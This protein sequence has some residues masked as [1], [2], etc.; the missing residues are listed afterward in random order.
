M[1]IRAVADLH[2][3]LPDI[4]PCDLLLV[5]GDS[6][7]MY[8][9]EPEYQRE[10]CGDV[11]RPWLDSIDAEVVGIGGNHDFIFQADPLVPRDLPWH[12][13]DDRMVEID[14]LKIWGHP[15]VPHLRD[16]AFF[17]DD[18]MMEYIVDEIPDDVD[19][20]LSH[21]PGLRMGSADRVVYGEHVGCPSLTERVEQIKP[22]AFVCGHIHEGNGFYR[23]TV[24]DGF[25]PVYNVAH[26]DK[27]YRPVNPVVE[28]RI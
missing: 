1:I 4:K 24:D 12:Y 5:G 13:A 8:S 23:L 18:P 22:K 17:A 25:V 14:G 11:F 16:W 10:W 28:I 6:L 19:I 26:M 20:L 15:W 21:G 9:H 7:P 27:Q 2:G 3:H